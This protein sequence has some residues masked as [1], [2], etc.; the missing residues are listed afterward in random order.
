MFIATILSVTFITLAALMPLHR[1]SFQVLYPIA[2]VRP[3][4]LFSAAAVATSA[5]TAAA[6]AAR[7]GVRM[8]GV[9]H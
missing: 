1:K 5:A 3:T 4:P 9:V 2:G 6:T 7:T 8:G